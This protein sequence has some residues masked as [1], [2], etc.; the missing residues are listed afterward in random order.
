RSQGRRAERAAEA[1]RCAAQERAGRAPVRA[2]GLHGAP[3]AIS[4]GPALDLCRMP[5][6]GD[7]PLLMNGRKS[8]PAIEVRPLQQSD[9]AD[10]RRLWT[11]SGILRN[12]RAGGGLPDD[13]GTAVHR[14]RV[15]TEGIS[16]ADRRQGGGP[17]PLYLSPLLLVD[18]Q[19]LL[20]AGFVRGPR[21][22]RQGRRRGTDRG[23]APGGGEDR[24]QQRLL[25]DA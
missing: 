5:S 1:A 20:S 25:D 21:R 22:A 24:R 13:L 14:R 19:Q 6:T 4:A 10:W 12:D 16:R 18:R 8:M 17:D 7:D 2:A 3:A 11:A 9:H 15:R 23:G